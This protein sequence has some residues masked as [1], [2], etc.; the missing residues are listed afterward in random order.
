MDRC[1]I[2]CV[3]ITIRELR[4]S[5]NISQ[6]KLAEKSNLDRTY[7]SGIER[8]VRNISLNNLERVMRAFNITTSSFLELLA[9]NIL[10]MY[11]NDESKK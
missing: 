5:N 4:A 11:K 9:A 1:L 2:M 8:G 3:G 10:I 7:I 6:E